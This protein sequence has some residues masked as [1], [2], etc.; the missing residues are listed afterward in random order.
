MQSVGREKITNGPNVKENET[1]EPKKKTK[2]DSEKDA[3]ISVL[4][5]RVKVVGGNSVVVVVVVVGDHTSYILESYRID[6]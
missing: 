5:M 2:T 6:K 4:V 1:H 3:W